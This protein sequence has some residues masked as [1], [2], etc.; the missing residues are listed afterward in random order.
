MISVFLFLKQCIRIYKLHQ[1][2]FINNLEDIIMLLQDLF[3]NYY[4]FFREYYPSK[5]QI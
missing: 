5:E 2:N 1:K 3:Y 4:L